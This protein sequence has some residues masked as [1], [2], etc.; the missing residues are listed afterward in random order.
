LTLS[1]W[2]ITKQKH[3][4]SAFTGEGARLYGGRWNSPGTAMIYTAQSKSLAVLEVLVHLDS[5]ELL[6]KYVLFEVVIDPSCVRELAL[7]SLPRNW[8]ASPAPARVRAIGD[9]WVAGGSSVVLR[10]P[11]TLVPG[12][13]NFL[14][15]P[16][17]SSFL[18]LLFGKPLPFQFDPRFAR[19]D[20][21]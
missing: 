4:K 8:K 17:H 11:S 21:G 7:S 16:R 13:S 6:K 5:S 20:R 9:D 2:R 18:Q 14:L 15:N 10:V 3:A 12:E 19:S 1:A